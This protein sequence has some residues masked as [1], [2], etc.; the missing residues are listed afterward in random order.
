MPRPTGGTHHSASITLKQ[1]SKI[2]RRIMAGHTVRQVSSAMK[3]DYQLVYR[4]ATGKTWSA[5]PPSGPV[6]ND[7]NRDAR[8]P[9]RN[10]SL[11]QQHILWKQRRARVSTRDLAAKAKLSTSSVRRLVAEFE[12]MLAARVSQLQLTSGSYEPARRKYGLSLNE[13]EALDHKAS[14]TTL[15]GRLQ[16]TVDRGFP[17]LERKLNGSEK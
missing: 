4:I 7:E 9:K 14:E 11:R 12:A 8:G 10:V 15:P 6:A 3:L 1:A 17:K 16:R 2:K 5:A 13:A